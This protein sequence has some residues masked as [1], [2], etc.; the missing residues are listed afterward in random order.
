MIGLVVVKNKTDYLEAGLFNKSVRLVP[1]PDGL[2]EMSYKFLGLLPASLGE[3]DQVRIDREMVNG[4]DIL[5]VVIDGSE[6]LAGERLKPGP[7]PEKWQQRPG[8]HEII[9]TGDDTVLA[10]DVRLRYAKRDQ[11]PVI[12]SGLTSSSNSSPVSRPS[13]RQASR[14]VSP[15][16]SAVWAIWAALS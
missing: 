10:K 15:S 1:R 12:R 5:K 8:E 3:L 13:C 14:S 9:N 4:R 7:I 16:W 2:L 6:F 11:N